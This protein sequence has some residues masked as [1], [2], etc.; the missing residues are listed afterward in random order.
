MKRDFDALTSETF[1]LIVV[2]GGIMGAG[3]ARDAALRGINTLLL[4]KNDFASGSDLPTIIVPLLE[5]DFIFE[6]IIKS[7]SRA[8][9]DPRTMTAFF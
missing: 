8:P 9:F 2:G 1:D 5:L 7:I 4:D 3:I 6:D